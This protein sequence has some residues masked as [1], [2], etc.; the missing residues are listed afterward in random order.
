MISFDK[1]EEIIDEGKKTAKNF[2]VV[3]DS[4]AKLQY[5][6]KEPVKVKVK[7]NK[8]LVD[9]IIIKGNKKYTNNYILGKLQLNEGDS[10]S[11]NDISKKINTLTA[12]KNFKRI[13]YHFKKSFKGKKLELVVKEEDIKSYLRFGLHYDLLYKSAVLLNYNHKKLLTQNDELSLDVGIGDKIRYDFQYF[14]DNG[15]LPS[16]GIKSRYN[17]FNNDFLYN[18][19]LIDVRYAD[20]TNS[21]FLQTT[22]VLYI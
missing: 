13:D 2:K 15:L 18:G 20:F 12:S 7:K 21:F 9:R 6:K 1:K 22:M 3:F 11:Y 17:T 4:I 10:V 19:D 14:V 16:Y 8:F 5:N